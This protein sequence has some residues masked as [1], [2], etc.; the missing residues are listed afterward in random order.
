MS[1]LNIII[2]EFS[3]QLNYFLFWLIYLIWWMT[4]Y[5][6][7]YYII[8]LFTSNLPSFCNNFEIFNKSYLLTC[9]F[10]IPI[11]S[12]LGLNYKYI[13]AIQVYNLFVLR[14]KFKRQLILCYKLLSHWST[15]LL[16]SI[17]VKILLWV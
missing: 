16:N 12:L 14:V 7:F 5:C 15:K 9:W 11:F 4:L 2:N 13:V 8:I 3:K 1:K 17:S 10:E 6:I